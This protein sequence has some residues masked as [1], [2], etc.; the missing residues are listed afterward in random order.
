VPIFSQLRILTDDFPASFR[1][2]RDVLGLPPQ[3]GHDP[4]GPYGCFKLGD[5]STDIALFE[6]GPM[7]AALGVGGE[8]AYTTGG[9]G[10]VLVIRVDDVDA[11]HAAAVAAGADS[12][13]TPA[14]QPGWGTRVAHLRAPEGTVVEFCSW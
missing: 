12:L 13:T 7:A 14:D 9:F 2:Y 1:F 4:A 10:S 11:A 8:S 6:R 5:G 3:E